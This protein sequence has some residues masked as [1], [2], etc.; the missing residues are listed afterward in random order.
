MIALEWSFHGHSWSCD[1][2]DALEDQGALVLKY[3][4][5][6]ADVSKADL[7]Q[8]VGMGIDAYKDKNLSIPQHLMQH[9]PW[10]CET[11]KIYDEARLIADYADAAIIPGGADVEQEFY[12]PGATRYGL[13]S[14]YA[15]SI[16]EYALIHE[17]VT[18]KKPL[19]G[20]CRGMQITNTYFKGGAIKNVHDQ[21]GEQKL[22]FQP[23]KAGEAFRDILGGEVWGSSAHSQALDQVGEGLEVALKAD[24]VIKA[25]LSEDG[26][27]L[28]T[29]FH[30]ERY[31]ISK[32]LEEGLKTENAELQ[33]ELALGGL[34]SMYEENG[35]FTP[36]LTLNEERQIV[37]NRQ[38][39]EQ[40]ARRY[41]DALNEIVK[42][43]FQL[44]NNNK[45]IA[46]FLDRAVKQMET[47]A[48]AA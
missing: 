39:L 16:K 48:P 25:A 32:N 46:Y 43:I 3:P 20:I 17:F 21:F 23:T 28:L 8:E 40:W 42:G 19:M 26:N 13:Y 2:N 29:Q 27:V 15:K 1:V 44:Q 35:T 5:T 11:Q 14:N 4:F 7:A 31:I 10:G 45:I 37:L 12:I 9:G 18:R 34:Y 41:E 30:P 6:V 22:E 24:G 33:Q 36:T 47:A 38:F